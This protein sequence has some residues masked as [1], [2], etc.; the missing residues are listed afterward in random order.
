MKL[1]EGNHYQKAIDE[2]RSQLE[3]SVKSSHTK[4]E[5]IRSLHNLNG[6]LGG[7]I[8]V[9]EGDILTLNDLLRDLDDN[10]RRLNEKLNEV[11]FSKASTY[12]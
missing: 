4:D 2:I 11:I 3:E 7:Q 9:L 8:E 6:S 5:E 1:T 12:K 10:N